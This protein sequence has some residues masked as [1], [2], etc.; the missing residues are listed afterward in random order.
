MTRFRDWE[1]RLVDYLRDAKA[2]AFTWG[3]HDCATFAA[4]AVDAVCGS[5]LTSAF[6]GRYFDESSAAQYLGS[7]GHMTLAGIVR[8]RLGC[9]PLPTPLRAQRGDLAWFPPNDRLG[10]PA[11]GV[12]GV[13]YGGAVIFTPTDGLRELQPV[14]ASNLRALAFPVGA[15]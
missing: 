2:R 15:R 4:G 1:R 5:E 13:F 14:V 12:L 8:E 6:I 11:I 10:I 7:L 9:A 3:Q